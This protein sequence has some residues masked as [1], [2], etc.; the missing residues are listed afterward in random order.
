MVIFI[1]I[2]IPEMYGVGRVYRTFDYRLVCSALYSQ[3]QYFH[4]PFLSC[5]IYTFIY[6]FVSKYIIYNQKKNVVILTIKDEK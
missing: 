2:Q 3:A 1:L 6:I 4:H 5:V